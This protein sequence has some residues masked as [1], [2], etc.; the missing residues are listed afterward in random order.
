M[1]R[2]DYPEVKFFPFEK[3]V[4]LQPLLK[5]GIDYSSGRHVLILN[6]DMIIKEGSIQ[7]LLE[8]IKENKDVGMV[9][10]QLLSFNETWQ[11]SCFRFYKPITIVYRRT[12]LKKFSFAKK[13]LD[14]FLMSDYDKKSPKN[15][16]WLMGSAMMIS[17]EALEKV[18]PTDSRFFMYLE[19]VDW[20]RRFWENGFRVVYYPAAKMIHYHGKGSGRQG[21]L[22][23]LLMNRL[24]W[25]HISSALKYFKKYYKKPNPREQYQKN[26]K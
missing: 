23:S 25:I 16:D 8:Y 12:F 18:G 20:C 24:T 14:W 4:G 22:R 5:A 19:D 1:M 17:R 9:G 26:I 15:V 21:V 11:P 10:P 3:N 13:H 2:E 6:G 7:K